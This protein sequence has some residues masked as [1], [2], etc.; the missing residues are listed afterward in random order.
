MKQLSVRFK[1]IVYAIW[2]IL[3]LGLVYILIAKNIFVLWQFFS[4]AFLWY[5][6]LVLPLSL[7]GAYWF[8]RP[9]V[10]DV[11]QRARI[12]ITL[13]GILLI[14]SFTLIQWTTL[15]TRYGNIEAFEKD[16]GSKLLMLDKG[17]DTLSL[18]ERKTLYQEAITGYYDLT[19][20]KIWTFSG[21]IFI[22]CLLIFK[23]LLN[24][25]EN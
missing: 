18:F 12:L 5:I 2:L 15:T 21:S 6:L 1:L 14:G 8:I 16:R 9:H 7:S 20:K 24:K 23:C 17:V 4:A 10:P 11:Y 25:N 19:F 3:S 22:F 13:A